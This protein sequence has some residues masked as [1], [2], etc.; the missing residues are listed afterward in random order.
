MKTKLILSTLSLCFLSACTAMPHEAEVEVDPTPS[1]ESAIQGTVTAVDLEHLA[2]D[3][4]AI[5]TIETADEST[6]EIRVPTFLDC[7]A[8]DVAHVSQIKVGDRVE[9]N[10]SAGVNGSIIPCESED[11]YLRVLNS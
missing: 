2:V 10:G 8:K 1:P 3:G 9:V 7:K 5:I 6:L 4:P 11:H